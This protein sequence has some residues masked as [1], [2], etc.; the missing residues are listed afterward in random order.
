MLTELLDDFIVESSEFVIIVV[1]VSF[2][3]LVEVVEVL[4]LTVTHPTWVLLW[5]IVSRVH[6]I[7]IVLISC[8][9]S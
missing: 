9:K 1:D 7:I 3:F 5:L 6:I 8:M 4:Q 2:H